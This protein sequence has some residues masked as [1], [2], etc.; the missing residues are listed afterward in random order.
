MAIEV[1]PSVISRRTRSKLLLIQFCYL[2]ALSGDI[3]ANP[4]PIRDPCGSCT[5]PVR[6]NQNAI[7]C[8]ML[9]L[10]ALEMSHT[11][12]T[13]IFSFVRI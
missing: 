1:K 4:G 12:S 10:V 13:E 8:D 6:K 9:L 11:Q 5:R 7:C 2:L 3:E